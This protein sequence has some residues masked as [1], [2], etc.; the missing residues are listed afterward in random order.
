MP[1]DSAS[2]VPPPADAVH[3]SVVED[4]EEGIVI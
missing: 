3:N 1:A 4:E 2:V